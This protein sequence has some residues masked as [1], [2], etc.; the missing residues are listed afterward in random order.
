MGVLVCIGVCVRVGIW[1]GVYVYRWGVCIVFVCLCKVVL[2]GQHNRYM[3]V[4]S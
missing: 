3:T 2:L 4:L 1:R